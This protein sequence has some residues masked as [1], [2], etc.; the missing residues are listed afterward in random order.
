MQY[1]LFYNWLIL[2][3]IMFSRFIHIVING[4]LSLSLK[5]EYYLVVCIC[6]IFFMHS[7]VRGQL[8]C[9]H[10]SAILNNAAMNMEVQVS[11]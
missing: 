9:F 3:S 2:L 7:H 4:R 6:P 5:A 8:G 10:V 11:F 1:L